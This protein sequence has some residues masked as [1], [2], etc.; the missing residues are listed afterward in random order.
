MS[1][2]TRI[3]SARCSFAPCAGFQAGAYAEY[4]VPWFQTHHNVRGASTATT[5]RFEH[6]KSG[7]FVRT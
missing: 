6:P 2:R 5:E 4:S 3:S 7:N 1:W